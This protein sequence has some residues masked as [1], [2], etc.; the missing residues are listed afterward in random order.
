MCKKKNND[1]IIV[2]QTDKWGELL[3][4]NPFMQDVTTVQSIPIQF[5]FICL[6][7]KKMSLC[8]VKSGLSRG[9]SEELVSIIFTAKQW[10]WFDCIL[11]RLRKLLNY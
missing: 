11:F 1:N 6:L 9:C 5:I 3:E 10:R 8:L 4:M 2:V 7:I